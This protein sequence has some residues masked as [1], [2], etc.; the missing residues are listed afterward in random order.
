[1]KKSEALAAIKT[2]RDKINDHPMPADGSGDWVN[3]VLFKLD[4]ASDLLEFPK[5]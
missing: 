2:L 4:E 5:D 3:R 1:M